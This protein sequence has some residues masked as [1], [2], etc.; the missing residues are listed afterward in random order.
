MSLTPDWLSDDVIDRTQALGR[1]MAIFLN[2][3]HEERAANPA[4][5]VHPHPK[6][7]ELLEEVQKERRTRLCAGYDGAEPW[8]DSPSTP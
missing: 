8:S 7:L 1:E 5:K 6:L 2:R 3:R 4:A